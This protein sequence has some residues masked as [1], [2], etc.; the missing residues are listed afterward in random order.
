MMKDDPS[1]RA[2][3]RRWYEAMA[4]LA[5]GRE[6]LGRGARLGGT[7]PA[8]LPRLGRDAPRPRLDRGDAGRARQG[9]PGRSRRNESLVDPNA[10]RSP[11]QPAP[12]R[13][14]REHLENAHRA[15]RA[16]VAVD[17]SLAEA[18]LRLG[19]VAW[20][21]GE[22]A[23]ARSALE[24]V[25]ARKPDA[26]TAF[27]AHLFLGRLDEDAGRLADA[28]RVLRG[29]AR[30]RPALA[31]RTARAQPRPPAARRR[32]GRPR[33]G[34]E[35]GRLGGPP[36]GARRVLALS[37]GAVRRGRGPA[38]GAAR[39]RP[40]RDRP[41][42]RARRRRRRPGPAAPDLRGGR[43]G[44]VRGRLR[45]RRQP[46]RRRASPRPT[47]SCATT[48]RAGRSSSSRW[49]R[50]LSPPSSSSTRAAAWRARSSSAFRP[51]GGRCSA[52]CVPTTRPPW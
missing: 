30:P 46:A 33:G 52:G 26:A 29:R 37:L 12:P 24:E 15:L 14:V 6:P 4:G 31:V 17:P 42:P 35:G 3:A 45:D 43:R 40:R 10:R 22:T 39:G 16:A 2:F 9:A 50:C 13:E 28:A 48:A 49:S 18:R 38:R 21:L 51:R 19:R 25:L 44:R 32:G 47:S 34:G 23:E 8:R 27:L 7:G 36:P 5:A 20:R 1:H 11:G 41:R